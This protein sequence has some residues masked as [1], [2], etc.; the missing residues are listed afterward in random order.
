[1]VLRLRNYI[2]IKKKSTPLSSDSIQRL[3]KIYDCDEDI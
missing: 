1:M 3:K 2:Q